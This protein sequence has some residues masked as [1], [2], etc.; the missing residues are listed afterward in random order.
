ML[1]PE[2]NRSL[3]EVGPGTPMGGLLRRYWHPI[4][5]VSEF[6]AKSI[7]PVRL[8]GEDLVLFKTL[9]GEYGLIGRRCAHR[10]SDLSFGFVEKDGLRCV[11]HGWQYGRTGVCTHR[12]FD[13]TV[14]P[15]APQLKSKLPAYP[16][17][18]KA[19]LLWAYM[20]DEPA[21]ELP[22][23]ET[24]S[25]QNC[26]TQIAIAEV[27]CNWLQCQENTVDPVHF[28]WM[29]NNALQ[30][31]AGDFGEYSPKTLELKVDDFE[32]GLISRRY[33]EG[34][35][36]NTP[37]WSVGR[38]ILWPNGWYF[39]H[40]FEWKV[41][42]DDTN[43]LFVTWSLLHVPKECEPYTQQT[44]P[45]WFAPVKDEKGDWI[46]SHVGNQDVVAWVSQGAIADRTRE[47]LCASD[48]GVV[49]LRRRLFEDLE[50][51]ASGKDPRGIIRDPV[52]NVRVELPCLSREQLMNGL[53]REQMRKHPVMGP[54]LTEFYLMAGQPDEVREEFE[55]A[56]TVK[57]SRLEIHKFV[58]Q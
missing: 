35:D 25:W 54:Y 6:N 41:P 10:G 43:T 56:M 52:K 31:R 50:A 5:G 58:P 40:H 12:P 42:I 7:K 48:R 36:T 55:R 3:T 29:H 9:A 57:G 24:F 18:A 1:T 11:Y 26:F 22:D 46:Q 20:A 33:R 39:G 15:S 4:A 53:P 21:P 37:L 49:T 44:I 28:E 23:W 45:T 14:N 47:T 16:V 19:G 34:T 51:V 17:K 8:F 30:R 27:P 32:Y 2:Q 38:A 13:E